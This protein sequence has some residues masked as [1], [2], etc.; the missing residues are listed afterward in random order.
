MA[1][2]SPT[3][4]N[5]GAVGTG[6]TTVTLSD[7]TMDVET[8][9]LRQRV[10]TMSPP[11]SS[12]PLNSIMFTD[13]PGNEDAFIYHLTES[14]VGNFTAQ[15]SFEFTATDLG[16]AN[17]MVLFGY[18][19]EVDDFFNITNSAHIRLEAPGTD[20]PVIVIA[21]ALTQQSS[22][23]LLD[24]DTRYWY[25][26][27]RVGVALECKVYTDAARTVQE[28]STLT[29][30]QDAADEY[31]HVYA[32]STWNS[33][34]AL[35]SSGIIYALEAATGLTGPPEY[36]LWTELDSNNRFDLGAGGPG[37]VEFIFTLPS[38]QGNLGTLKEVGILNA[39]TDGSLFSRIVHDDTS[40]V[41]GSFNLIYTVRHTQTDS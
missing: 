8:G 37:V 14:N 35:K 34:T 4:P 19:D 24:I 11:A 9:D 31:T 5:K 22:S 33:G 29:V 7:T 6:S 32:I 41:D 36:S 40:F 12:A 13:L 17:R 2:L 25:T 16:A 39:A 28:G 26:F 20:Q 27:T 3:E 15:G 21:D 1:G 18:A 30:N 23:L 10:I 38:T